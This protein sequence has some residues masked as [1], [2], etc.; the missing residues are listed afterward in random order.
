MPVLPSPRHLLNVRLFPV[1]S[2]SFVAGS[3]SPEKKRLSLSRGVS[4]IRGGSIDVPGPSERSISREKSATPVVAKAESSEQP[5]AREE[6]KE[7][8]KERKRKAKE[9]KELKKEEKRLAEVCVH[10][11]SE[12]CPEF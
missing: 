7:E 2:S 1:P 11:F 9:A 3:L 8:R 4:E 5:K 10:S 12:T 6:T